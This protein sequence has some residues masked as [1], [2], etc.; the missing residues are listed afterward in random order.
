[1]KKRGFGKSIFEKNTK[2]CT[3]REECGGRKFQAT[4]KR[5]LE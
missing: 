2:S 3:L 4:L 1:M 5:R